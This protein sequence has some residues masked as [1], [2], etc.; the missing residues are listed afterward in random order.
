LV[1]AKQA[2]KLNG[3]WGDGMLIDQIIKQCRK[4]WDLEH[5]VPVSQRPITAAIA[6]LDAKRQRLIVSFGTSLAEYDLATGEQTHRTT[7]NSFILSLVPFRGPSDRLIAVSQRA[8][9][10]ISLDD[11]S[12]VANK[13][14]D[15]TEVVGVDAGQSEIVV[16]FSNDDIQAFSKNLELLDSV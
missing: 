10:V 5:V 7:S 11:L 12:V 4:D 6:Q 15:Q 8:I 9:S 16:T 13:Q 3:G 14:F 1:Q 2:Y